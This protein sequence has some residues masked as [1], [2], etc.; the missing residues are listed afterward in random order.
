[1]ETCVKFQFAGNTVRLIQSLRDATDAKEQEDIEN[2]RQSHAFQD[3]WTQKWASDS[4]WLLQ[5]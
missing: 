1:M 5:L 2:V 3:N 4:S